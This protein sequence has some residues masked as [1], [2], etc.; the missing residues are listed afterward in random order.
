MLTAL[1]VAVLTLVP[2][3]QPLEGPI[4]TPPS[5]RHARLLT[6]RSELQAARPRILLP[7][8]LTTV[9]AVTALGSLGVLWAAIFTA[10][11][12]AFSFATGSVVLLTV[13]LVLLAAAIPVTAVGAVK[14]H[15]AR[16]ERRRI[17]GL[18]EQLELEEAGMQTIVT[19]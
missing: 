14:L 2:G 13:G 17:D 11:Y 15:R 7:I 5:A 8:L 9:G 18:L 16:K 1:A 12:Y 19:F 6:E 3:A 10:T 4:V